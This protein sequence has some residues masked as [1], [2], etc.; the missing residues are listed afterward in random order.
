MGK[1]SP[2][3][4]H[5]PHSLTTP[6][7]NMKRKLNLRERKINT[8]INYYLLFLLMM[9]RIH[10]D[11]TNIMILLALIKIIKYNK[12]KLSTLHFNM[13]NIFNRYN[14]IG[15]FTFINIQINLHTRYITNFQW[16]KCTNIR[17]EDIFL[18]CFTVSYSLEK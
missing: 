13:L 18:T 15:T 9:S 8:T 6:V 3:S 16:T 2:F 5:I 1:Y 7:S 14:Y 4:H 12:Y 10:T 17:S 11:I